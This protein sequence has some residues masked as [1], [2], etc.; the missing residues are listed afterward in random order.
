MLAPKPRDF[1]SSAGRLNSSPGEERGDHH[2][3]DGEDPVTDK[4]T[5]ERPCHGFGVVTRGS[6]FVC[7]SVFVPIVPSSI[8]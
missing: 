8:T 7:R 2:A 6:R 3:E 5:S 1:H 4:R